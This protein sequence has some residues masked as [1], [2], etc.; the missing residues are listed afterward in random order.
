MSWSKRSPLS[1]T[2]SELR[3]AVR[4]I[5]RSSK[6]GVTLVDRVSF[7]VMRERKVEKALAFD[8]DFVVAGFRLVGS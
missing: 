2:G 7:L 8:P 1:S 5:E 6:R 4:Q 3:R